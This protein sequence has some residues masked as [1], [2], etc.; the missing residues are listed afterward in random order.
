[1]FVDGTFNSSELEIYLSSAYRKFC[2]GTKFI[3]LSNNEKAAVN[4]AAGNDAR[5]NEILKGK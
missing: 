4:Q 1:M 2:S 5:A 3:A